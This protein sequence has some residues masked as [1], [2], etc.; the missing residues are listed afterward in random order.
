MK[1]DLLLGN[2]AASRV[3]YEKIR[4]LPIVDYH[5]HLSPKEIWED[6]PFENI[7]VAWLGGDH[8]KWRLMRAWGVPEE[9]ITGGADWKTKF[10]RYV[11]C[12]SLAAGNPLYLWSKMELSLFFGIETPL[13][14]ENAEKIWDE[15][16]EAIA[17]NK[18]S[19][20]KLIRDSRVE[21]IATTD[22]P[23]DDLQ[24]HRFL[25]QDDTFPTRIAPTFRMD[26]GL[27]IRDRGWCE[28]LSRLGE[29]A[30]KEINSY[31]DFLVALERRLLYFIRHGCR[32]SD[33]GIEFFPNGAATAQ[34]A[35]DTFQKAKCGLA[36][37]D[38][39]YKAFLGNAICRL[40][41]MYSA[42]GIIMQWH[43]SVKRNADPKKF[44]ALGADCGGDCIGDII[45]VS[46]LC[47]QIRAMQ[48][49][50]PLPEMV[51]YTL[52]PAQNEALNSVAGSF[53]GVKSGAAW[54]FCDHKSGI[55]KQLLNICETGHIA[56]FPGMLTDSRSFLS[57]ARHD[58]FRRILCQ[59]IGDLVEAGECEMQSAEAVCRRVAY[60][61]TAAWVKVRL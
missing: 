10:C 58:Y 49:K 4:T 60:E 21:Y 18:L 56:A 20:R 7:G 37:G 5:C 25:Q 54:W 34:E 23:T 32:F 3:L 46:R 36:V 57:Y 6:K 14:P 16:N 2:S 30:G 50:E 51:L 26:K 28:W 31:A 1:N 24:F 47:A 41:E 52:N 43:L 55:Q 11:E 33:L 22:D 29:E 48:E 61:N 44:R 12:V 42:N 8:Y 35:E 39:E 40:S 38:A 45:P 59:V 15:A 27:L 13:L 53:E 9:E 17:K 19:P